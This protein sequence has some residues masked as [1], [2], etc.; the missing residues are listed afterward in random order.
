MIHMTYV[1]L[2]TRNSGKSVY[3]VSEPSEM[4]KNLVD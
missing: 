1:K 2:R 3:T 4:K